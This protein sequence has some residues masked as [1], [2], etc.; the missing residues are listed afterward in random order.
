[1]QAKASV[2]PDPTG[3]CVNALDTTY[4]QPLWFGPW[5]A[6]LQVNVSQDAGTGIDLR[7]YTWQDAQNIVVHAMADG[8]WG[9]TQFRVAHAP[10][11]AFGNNLNANLNANLKANSNA[12]AEDNANVDAAAA[13]DP[14][15]PFSIGG[16]QQARGARL[17]PGWGSYPGHPDGRA[18]NRYYMEGSIE[19]L[20]AE[21]E[22]HFD[23][24]TRVLS[25]IPPKGFAASNGGKGGVGGMGGAE[26]LLTQTDTLFEFAG[27]SSDAGSRV[28]NIVVSNLS[29]SH[30][31]AQFFRPHEETSGG[32]YAT[33][34]SGA[35]KLENTTNVQ[36][37]S[38]DFTWVGGNGVFLSNSVKN[39]TVSANLFRWLGTSGVAVQ[40]KTGDALMD[41]RDGEAM[42]AAHGPGADNG[43]RLPTY[44][45]VS[46]NVFADYGVWDKQSACYHKALAPNNLFLNNVCFNSSRHGVNFQDGFGGGGVA[47][48]NVMFNLNRETSDTTAFNSWNRRNYITS[49][50]ADPR[51]PVLVPPSLNEWRRNLILGRDYY[52]FRDGNGNGLRNDDGASYYRHSSNV[53]YQTGMEFN[54]GTQVHS[55]GNLFIKAAWSLSR[56]PDVSSSFNDTF[57]DSGLRMGGSPDICQGFW[58]TTGKRGPTG[59][60][61]RPGIYTGDYSLGIANSTGTLA[62]KAAI[63]W[64]RYY[65]GY[66]LD[67]WQHHTGQDAHSVHVANTAGPDQ[68]PF[69]AAAIVAKARAMLYH[70]A[71]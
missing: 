67:E 55:E 58:N 7:T 49:D 48:G 62:P 11:G 9:G 29:F 43:V 17:G 1:M 15:L 31:S 54:G 16:F 53:M 64:S 4:N 26:L 50:P 51:V 69:G 21:G 34:R 71:P 33:H 46:H 10:D 40:G 70:A 66:T 30:T 41:G 24:A 19:F 27:S 20:D 68:G 23:P 35:V 6:S 42:A 22:W 36:L 37:L 65:C 18:G 61:P 63:D 3:S 59:G 38:N 52:G 45:T 14:V 2:P 8:E 56:T 12:N 32:D 39:T 13:K 57:V 60:Q 25:L 47:E 5:V 44:N 28:E